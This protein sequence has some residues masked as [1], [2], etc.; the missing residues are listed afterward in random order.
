VSGV[1][2]RLLAIQGLCQEVAHEVEDPTQ[3]V[4]EIEEQV[5]KAL[6]E[7]DAQPRVYSADEVRESLLAKGAEELGHRAYER[8]LNNLPLVV[9]RWDEAD[10]QIREAFVARAR[11]DLDHFVLPAAFPAST[12][13]EGR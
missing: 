6:A 9:P 7:D 8:A 3:A 13:E 4:S 1:R 10:E 5:R 2:A 11:S 12:S